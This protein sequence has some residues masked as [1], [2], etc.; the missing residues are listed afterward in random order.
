M[1]WDSAHGAR[2]RS[3]RVRVKFVDISP[4]PPCWAAPERPPWGSGLAYDISEEAIKRNVYACSAQ[5]IGQME[6]LAK[7]MREFV[8]TSKPL[9]E[10]YDPFEIVEREIL[11][12]C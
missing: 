3:S 7:W 6:V 11:G 2:S 12:W 8:N 4:M 9:D 10:L 1:V 5:Y